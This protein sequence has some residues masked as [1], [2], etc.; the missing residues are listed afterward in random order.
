MQLN[1]FIAVKRCSC[2]H[3][4][5]KTRLIKI[6]QSFMHLLHQLLFPAGSMR[7][8]GWWSTAAVWN[9]HLG[10]EAPA[11]SSTWV[12][13]SFSKGNVKAYQVI[14]WAQTR[15]KRWFTEQATCHRGFLCFPEVWFELKLLLWGLDSASHYVAPPT[16]GTIRRLVYCALLYPQML[17]P[18]FFTLWPHMSK[19]FIRTIKQRRKHSHKSS[20]F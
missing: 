12:T 6:L 3:C 17:M 10:P 4:E 14:R 1:A 19:R 5:Q 16:S 9:S 18:S 13:K 2:S 20:R 11:V 8:D 15:C 7:K